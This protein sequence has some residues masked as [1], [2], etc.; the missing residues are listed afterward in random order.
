MPGGAYLAG[1][2]TLGVDLTY[3]LT[4]RRERLEEADADLLELWRSA[5]ATAR[6]AA[7]TALTGAR[8]PSATATPGTVFNDATIGQQFSGDVDLRGQKLVVKAPKGTPKAAG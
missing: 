2:D 6:A 1:I 4:G 7:V 8:R 5:S 3:V